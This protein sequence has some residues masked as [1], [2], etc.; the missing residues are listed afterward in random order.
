MIKLGLSCEDVFELKDMQD[1]H[2]Y[3]LVGNNR[4]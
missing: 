1:F 4:A 2:Y 3:A